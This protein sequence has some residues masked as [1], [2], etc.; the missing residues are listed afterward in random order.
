MLAQQCLYGVDLAM[1]MLALVT[2]ALLIDSITEAKG[3]RSTAA[4]ASSP[5]PLPSS[6]WAVAVYCLFNVVTLLIIALCRAMQ[7]LC[8]L[9]RSAAQRSF[10]RS[11]AALRCAATAKPASLSCCSALLVAAC[12]L[13]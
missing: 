9:S 12:A 13:G 3:Q 5:P 6:W 8:S 2:L 7:P 4:S 1:V 10:G 11:E